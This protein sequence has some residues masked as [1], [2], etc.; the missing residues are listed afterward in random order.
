MTLGERLN[1]IV[2]YISVPHEV[3]KD[4]DYPTLKIPPLTANPIPI[5]PIS[6]LVR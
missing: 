1:A 6:R 4:A 5:R 3:A 2:F